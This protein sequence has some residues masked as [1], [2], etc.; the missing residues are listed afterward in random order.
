MARICLGNFGERRIDCSLRKGGGGKGFGALT[1][2]SYSGVDLG[3]E[4][5]WKRREADLGLVLQ[6]KRVLPEEHLSLKLMLSGGECCN[7]TC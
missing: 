4:M 6:L 2:F 5:N 1:Y 7:T 3:R